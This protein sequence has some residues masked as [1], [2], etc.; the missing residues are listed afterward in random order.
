[1]AMS[2]FSV[3]KSISQERYVDWAGTIVSD[4]NM[5]L[6]TF[7]LADLFHLPVGYVLDTAAGSDELQK[8]PNVARWWKDI[9]SR[10]SFQ[11]VKDSA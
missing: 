10:P 9:S 11:P 2:A 8:R 7:T 1:M 3:S 4:S 6:Q 5:P